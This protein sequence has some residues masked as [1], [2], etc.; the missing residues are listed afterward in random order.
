M[1][2]QSKNLSK[3]RVI[4]LCYIEILLQVVFQNCFYIPVLHRV[5][6]NISA[7]VDLIQSEINLHFTLATEAI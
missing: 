2:L 3:L 7:L 6:N 4:I 1:S 5:K